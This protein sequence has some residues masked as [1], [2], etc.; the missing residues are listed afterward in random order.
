MTR[1][2]PDEPQQWLNFAEEVMAFLRRSDG[3][4]APDRFVW[5][6]KANTLDQL[7]AFLQCF[8]NNRKDD[9]GLSGDQDAQS[10]SAA[11]KAEGRQQG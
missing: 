10:R 3:I 11:S 7:A 2:P 5:L 8:V 9:F 1:P 4:T 6:F